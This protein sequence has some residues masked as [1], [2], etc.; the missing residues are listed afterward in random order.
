MPNGN[1]KTNSEMASELID[2]VT[3]V[4][5]SVVN[6][7]TRRMPREWSAKVIETSGAISPNG[8]VQVYLN[9][10]NTQP[11]ITVKNKSF[12]TVNANDEVI[13]HSPSGSLSNVFMA[14]KK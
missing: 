6:K 12:E 1:K 8:N 11:P 13:L 9:G 10:D 3:K 14:W 7:L 5:T 2:L 4:A